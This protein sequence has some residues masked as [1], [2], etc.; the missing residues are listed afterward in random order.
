MNRPPRTRPRLD[1]RAVTTVEF[2]LVCIPFTAFLLAV[3]LIGLQYYLQQV[4]DYATQ[5]AARQ[6]QLGNVPANY[7][8]AQFMTTVFC[9]LF[10]QLHTC[11]NLFVDVR[12]VTDYQSLT[13]AGVTDA[14]GSTTT[15][16]F[17]FCPGSPGQLMYVH[18]VFLAPMLGGSLLNYGSANNA[19][20]ANA[21]FANE[22][23]GGLAVAAPAC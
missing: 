12:P 22:N 19:I 18:V 17:K 4:L 8:E 11:T 6:V 23:P 1:R 2:A 10:G 3:M 9:P 7:T 13:T 15:T 20:V 16:G 21:A 5:G 14:P